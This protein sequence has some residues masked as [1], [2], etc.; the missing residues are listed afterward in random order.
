MSSTKSLKSQKG[1]KKGIYSLIGC[2]NEFCR[3]AADSAAAGQ[4]VLPLIVAFEGEP[5]QLIQQL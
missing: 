5:D 3:G 4:Q 1:S 2:S